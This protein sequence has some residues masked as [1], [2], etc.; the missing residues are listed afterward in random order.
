MSCIRRSLEDVCFAAT[1]KL[2]SL[3]DTFVTEQSSQEPAALDLRMISNAG[4]Q[5]IITNSLG[6]LVQYGALIVVLVDLIKGNLNLLLFLLFTSLF[7]AGIAGA[8]L[9]QVI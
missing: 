6:K 9:L 7:C 1:G 3:L 8:C 5:V 2:E 4:I